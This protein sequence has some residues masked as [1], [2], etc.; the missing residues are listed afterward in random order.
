MLVCVCWLGRNL[1]PE[2]LRL[3]RDTICI[4]HVF[5]LHIDMQF[6]WNYIGI[7]YVNFTCS[8]YMRICFIST[9]NLKRKTEISSVLSLISGMPQKSLKCFRTII[10][11]LTQHNISEALNC[12]YTCNKLTVPSTIMSILIVLAKISFESFLYCKVTLYCQEGM[13]HRD[14]VC[15]HLI[16]FTNY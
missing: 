11:I 15:L 1:K 14:L 2:K 16:C 12:Q 10:L 5:Y 7:K 13:L 4:S 9:R 6:Y 8:T 3:S